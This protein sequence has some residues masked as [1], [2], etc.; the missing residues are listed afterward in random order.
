[1]PIFIPGWAPLLLMFTPFMPDWWPAAALVWCLTWIGFV[2]WRAYLITAEASR[3]AS[4]KLLEK[5]ESK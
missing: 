1:M 3:E 5:N 4:R 2:C